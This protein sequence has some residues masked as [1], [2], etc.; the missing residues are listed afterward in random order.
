M[1]GSSAYYEVDP[2]AEALRGGLFQ[3]VLEEV[4]PKR[5]AVKDYV[6]ALEERAD[7]GEAQLLEEGAQGGHSHDVFATDVDGAEEGDV[8]KVGYERSARST[9]DHAR[10]TRAARTFPFLRT[11]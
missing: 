11:T 3:G 5:A 7:A 4:G 10:P 2:D 8:H 1:V 6:P 9:A